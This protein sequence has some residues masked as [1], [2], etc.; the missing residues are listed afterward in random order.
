ML[1]HVGWMHDFNLNA[2]GVGG[3]DAACVM[4]QHGTAVKQLHQYPVALTQKA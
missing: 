1:L 3:R 4:P 2:C